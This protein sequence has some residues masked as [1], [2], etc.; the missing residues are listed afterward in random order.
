MPTTNAPTLERST[1][2]VATSAAISRQLLRTLAL[3][4][5]VTYFVLLVFKTPFDVSDP[6]G[7]AS[8]ADRNQ[9]QQIIENEP[10]DHLR[11]A[12]VSLLLGLLVG[13]AM[14]ARDA[15][16]RRRFAMAILVASSA[17]AASSFFGISPLA[18][19][20][21]LLLIAS[22]GIGVAVNALNTRPNPALG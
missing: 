1:M 13:N 4:L 21:I 6:D 12:T 20:P 9:T 14:L 11:T 22:Y 5:F 3:M 10:Y 19:Q 8:L 17:L 2:H 15:T 7:G 16:E 18:T